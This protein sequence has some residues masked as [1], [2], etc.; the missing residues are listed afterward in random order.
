MQTKIRMGLGLLIGFVL[1]AV[2]CSLTAISAPARAAIVPEWV[3][4]GPMGANVT[5]AVVVYDGDDLVYV[6]GGVGTISYNPELDNTYS[7][8][9][10]SGVWKEL[11]RIPVGVRG[12]AG[13]MGDDGKIY[14]FSGVNSSKVQNTQIY[15]PATDSWSS[16]ASTP[17]ALWEAKAATTSQGIFLVGGEGAFGNL[18]MY[19]PALDSWSAKASMPTSLLG[20]AWVSDGTFLY[21]F[22]GAAL[23]YSPVASAYVYYPWDSWSSLNDMP[24]PTASLAGALGPDG[25]FY[26]VGGGGDAGNVGTGYS[27]GYVYDRSTGEWAT[28]PDMSVGARYLGAVGTMDGRILAIGGNNDTAVLS[29]VE[30]MTIMTTSLALSSTSVGTGGAFLVTLSYDFAFAAPTSYNGNAYLLSGN[31]VVYSPRDF[32]S[33]LGTAFAFEMTVPSSTPPGQ[34]QLVIPSVYYGPSGTLLPK[35]EA[36]ISVVEVFTLQEQIDML[37][38]NVSALQAQLTALENSVGSN[39]TS[40]QAQLGALQVQLTVTQAQLTALLTGFGQMAAGQ[41]AAFAQMNATLVDLQG[42]LDQ[43]QT[44]IDRIENKADTGGMLSIVILVLVIVVIVLL[45]MMFMMSRKK[46]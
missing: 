26:V 7:Y 3:P 24:A 15:D 18:Y 30:S 13:A 31:N 2:P 12:A 40:M 25:L 39:L 4:S 6:V 19:D 21:Y 17:L 37:S 38:S 10:T 27:T 16:G 20:G 34:Y 23:G 9:T 43:F 42:R 11:A 22:G 32:Y 5:Q 44:Q 28:I 8:N 14:V 36:A 45:A 35:L 33:P 1:L 41:V 29:R 46:P